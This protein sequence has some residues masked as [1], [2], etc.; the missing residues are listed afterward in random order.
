MDTG[1]HGTHGAEPEVGSVVVTDAD[2]DTWFG[3]DFDAD[4][5]AVAPKPVPMI[6]RSSS[7]PCIVALGQISI[8][9][10]QLVKWLPICYD[11]NFNDGNIVGWRKIS[12]LSWGP[13]LGRSLEKGKTYSSK[14]TSRE[15]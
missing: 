10:G 5:G 7:V 3:M 14:T 1:M 8:E 6:V 13:A 12:A 11:T 9:S 2:T 15:I 4:V